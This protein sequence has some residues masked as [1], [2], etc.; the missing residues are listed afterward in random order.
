MPRD[1]SEAV[2]F[3]AS[4]RSAWITGSRLL[5]DGGEQLG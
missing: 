5:V 2:L 3:F 1:I 4:S